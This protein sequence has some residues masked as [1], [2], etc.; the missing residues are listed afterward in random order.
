M[1]IT[2]SPIHIL[3]A[4]SIGLLLAVHLGAHVPIV[5][6]TRGQPVQ[7]RVSVRLQEGD[8]VLTRSVRHESVTATQR[9]EQLIVCTKSYDA[10]A[11]VLGVRSRLSDDAALLLMQNGMGSQQRVVEAVPHALCAATSTEGAYRTAPFEVVHAGRGM[12]RIGPLRG[13]DPGWVSLFN[14]A[15]L[16]AESG[17]PIQHFLADKLRINAVINPLTVR[18]RCRNGELLQRPEARQ[19]MAKLAAE[20]DAILGANGY[21]FDRPALQAATDVVR[22]TAGN[23]SSMYQ[24]YQRGRPLEIDDINGYLVRLARRS[25]IDAPGHEAVLAELTAQRD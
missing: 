4:G 11:A 21:R 6:L 9:I 16:N 15:G 3:G 14:A 10:E 2:D 13:E 7:P 12:T 17:E 8:A 25:G 5:L 1:T 24:D 19:A 23:F 18:F 22:A 20:A